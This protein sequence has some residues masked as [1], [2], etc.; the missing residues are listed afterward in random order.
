MQTA[1]KSIFALVL[2]FVFIG[3]ANGQKIKDFLKDATDD[4]SKT[5][6]DALADR[7][8]EKA[9]D[10]L[11]KKLDV[12]LDSMFK[13]AYESD[14]TSS[15]R[16]YE[17]FLGSLDQQ[18]DV[19]DSYNFDLTMDMIMTDGEGEE[20][21]TTFLFDNNTKSFGVE[22]DEN[23]VVFDAENKI[24][25][26]YNLK[27][28]TAFAFSDSMMKFAG[29]MAA[30]E[31][32]PDYTITKTSETKTILGYR[33]VKYIGTSSTQNFE[34][35]I[36]NDFQLDWTKSFESLYNYMD[37]RNLQKMQSEMPGMMFESQSTDEDGTIYKN[38]VTAINKET[39]ALISSDFNFGAAYD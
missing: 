3:Q 24:M 26:T 29:K 35:F 22:M 11:V 4:I 2:C 38:R 32:V 1:F 33:C 34:A 14:T 10:Y 30:N 21:P 31:V 15:S 25:V 17:E 28:K 19:P 16:S 18:E 6:G 7:V 37:S 5:L 23:I 8:V 20:T 13:E 36:S 12:K 9:A 27:E 39:R